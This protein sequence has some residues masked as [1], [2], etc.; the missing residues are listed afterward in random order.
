MSPKWQASTPA[1]V[2]ILSLP[3]E[4]KTLQATQGATAHSNAA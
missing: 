2:A 3:D 4:A 1:I